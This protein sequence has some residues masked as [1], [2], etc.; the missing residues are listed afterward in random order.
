MND[1]VRTFLRDGLVGCAAAAFVD[2]AGVNRIRG[3]GTLLARG[4]FEYL[5]KLPFSYLSITAILAVLGP[6]SGNASRV[7]LV[8][9]PGY[10]IRQPLGR[11]ARRRF[12]L[13]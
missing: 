8:P 1:G 3:I 6:F 10:I 12:V 11:N 13:A 7:T 4:T 2:V 5:V 9:A